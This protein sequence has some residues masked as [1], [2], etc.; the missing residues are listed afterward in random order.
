MTWILETEVLTY[1]PTA[2]DNYISGSIH[3]SIGFR[4][5]LTG[6]SILA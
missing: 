3:T 6:H 2:V 5:V 4:L 1:G